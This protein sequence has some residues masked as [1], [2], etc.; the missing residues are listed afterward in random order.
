MYWKRDSG[1]GIFL[2]VLRNF[3][4]HLF[5]G[6]L[7]LQKFLLKITWPFAQL[8]VCDFH[9]LVVSLNLYVIYLVFVQSWSLS[10]RC[11][12][13]AGP[14][15]YSIDHL[16]LEVSKELQKTPSWLQKNLFRDRPNSCSEKVCKNSHKW[17]YAVVRFNDF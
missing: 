11:L 6:R 17:V 10:V 3:L 13:F 2:W 8:R 5:I 12:V 15:L 1:T 7:L 14:S 16:F 4:E 9:L